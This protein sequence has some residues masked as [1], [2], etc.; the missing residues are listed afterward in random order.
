VNDRYETGVRLEFSNGRPTMTSVADINRVLATYG[1]R[2]W[3]LDLRGVPEPVRQLLHQPTLN[4]AE[5][6][7]VREHFLLSR[8]CLLDV[9]RE[10]GRTPQVPGGGNMSTLDSTHGILYPQLYIAE[11]GVDYSR[12]DRFHVNVSGDS[13][14]VDEVGQLLTGGSLRVLQQLPDQGVVTLNIDCIGGET[15]WIVT[16]DGTIPH[17]GSISRGQPG[18]KIL[19]QVIGP[20]QWEMKYIDQPQE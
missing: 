2:I 11:P 18:M 14:G 5:S 3:P 1:S 4:A 12:F 19:V 15:G 10:A 7:Q 6:T 8:K 13:T 16:Y 17:M 9:I 20:A